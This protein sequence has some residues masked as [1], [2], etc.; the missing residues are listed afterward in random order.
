MM[1]RV[2]TLS[3]FVGKHVNCN[4]VNK[5]LNCETIKTYYKL[6]RLEIYAALL[7]RIESKLWMHSPCS[8]S[9]NH[10][11]Y[12]RVCPL[13]YQKHTNFSNW[14]EEFYYQKIVELYSLFSK[15]ISTNTW[16]VLI[17][18]V[19][20]IIEPLLRWSNHIQFIANFMASIILV[21]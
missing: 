7:L 4:S 12:A 9:D 1:W 5:L 15:E 20:V 10:R 3:L 18:F 21:M 11:K 17:R 6:F 19:L 2:V 16:K 8:D 14:Y 13:W